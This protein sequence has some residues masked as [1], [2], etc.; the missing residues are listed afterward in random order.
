M[1]SINSELKPLHSEHKEH[2]WAL[3]VIGQ[4]LANLLPNHL[5]IDF[6]GR[7]YVVRGQ[8]KA[9]GTSER[10]SSVGKLLSK[11]KS[12]S[13]TSIEQPP[14]PFERTYTLQQIQ[15]LGEGGKSRRKNS[16]QSPDINYLGERLRAVGKIIEAKG[17]QL[18]KLTMDEFRVVFTYRESKGET[19]EEERTTPDL[20]R[21]RRGGQ[22]RRFAGKERDIWDKIS[23]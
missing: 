22:L 13:H 23:K 20:Y 1:L 10:K 16:A 8:G 7:V 2:G 12:R 11:L 9:Q 17:G 5:E 19:I 4:D 14:V 6:T 21:S 18:I 15:R 3:R